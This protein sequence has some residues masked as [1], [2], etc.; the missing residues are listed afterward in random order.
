MTYDNGP[1]AYGS[2]QHDKIKRDL[3]R[4]LREYIK[5]YLTGIA[6]TK[7]ERHQQPWADDDMVQSEKQLNSELPS[8]KD[9]CRIDVAAVIESYIL[10]F[11]IKT[12]VK[13]LQ[14]WPEQ[15]RDYQSSGFTPILVVPVELVYESAPGHRLI[16]DTNHI[17]AH[18]YQF[19]WLTDDQP[20]KVDEAFMT[21]Q[22]YDVPPDY[23]PSCGFTVKVSSGSG[24]DFSAFCNACHWSI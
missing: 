10:A 7:D 8:G 23:C 24:T 18:D 9:Y 13:D 1:G 2:N 6:F 3:E 16:T 5:R 20:P 4:R 12:S 19:H 17:I 22:P 21:T 14:N 11:E 15:K